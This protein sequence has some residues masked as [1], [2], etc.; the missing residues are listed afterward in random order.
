MIN[1]K[2]FCQLNIFNPCKIKVPTAIVEK[3]TLWRNEIP[4]CV[5]IG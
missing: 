5:K 4:A 3:R 2:A 1:K